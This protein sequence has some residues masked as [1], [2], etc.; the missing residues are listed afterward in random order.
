MLDCND[1][2]FQSE[3][4]DS[5]KPVLVKY[6]AK[7]CGPCKALHSRLLEIEQK[8]T[9]IKFVQ[10]DVDDNS[11]KCTSGYS[12]RGIPTMILFQNGKP[13]DQL[14]GDQSPTNI[15]VLLNKAQ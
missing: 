4:L 11:N 15:H 9:D 1:L 6:T 2:N 12:V 7:W 13:V 5:K 3:V 8:R 10:I 14:V